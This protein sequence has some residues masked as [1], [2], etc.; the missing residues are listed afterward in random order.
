VL[1]VIDGRGQVRADFLTI[2]RT[3]VI[4]EKCVQPTQS[5]LRE[6]VRSGTGRAAAL[7]HWPVYGKTGTTTGNADA[8]FVGWSEDRVLG[9]WMGRRRGDD[10]PAL[11]G[12]GAP[13]AYFRRLANSANEWS[14]HQRSLEERGVAVARAERRMDPS[15]F[16]DWFSTL[17]HA[18][19][20]PD[21][22]SAKDSPFR[23]K[24][25]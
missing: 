3:R 13:A 9:I 4:P 2:V 15:K 6:V 5:M 19:T 24:R 10:G 11:A 21:A 14:A 12:A 18:K 23:D 22:G 20:G 1:A 8:W 25:T 16:V 17:G 7:K